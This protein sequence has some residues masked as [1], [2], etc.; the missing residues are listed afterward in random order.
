MASHFPSLQELD[1]SLDNSID[2][3][4]DTGEN[5]DFLKRE[6]E[7][8]GNLFEATDTFP[9]LLDSEDAANASA[10]AEFE[11]SYPALDTDQVG[12]ILKPLFPLKPTI[13]S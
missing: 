4:G 10:T 12:I 11:K 8:L 2:T 9:V 1:P 3:A 6:K 13:K 7:A 5:L